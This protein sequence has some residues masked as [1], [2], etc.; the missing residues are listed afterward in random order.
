M[1]QKSEHFSEIYIAPDDAAVKDFAARVLQHEAFAGFQF[2][3]VADESAFDDIFDEKGDSV[4]AAV[5][6]TSLNESVRNRTSVQLV[7]K[8]LM[9]LVAHRLK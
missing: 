8:P 9:G 2:N 5:M 3:F 7:H 1:L 6:F 4:Y